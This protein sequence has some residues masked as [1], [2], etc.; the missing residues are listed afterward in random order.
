MQP[1][2]LGQTETVYVCPKDKSG[3]HPVPAISRNGGIVKGVLVAENGANYRTRGALRDRCLHAGPV[4]A[5]Q[6]LTFF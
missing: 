2:E 3:L 4:E 5:E 6:A 1:R